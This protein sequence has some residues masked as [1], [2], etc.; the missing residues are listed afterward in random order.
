VITSWLHATSLDCQ[1]A[2]GGRTAEVA[3]TTAAF[4]P[5][6]YVA[7]YYATKAY[8]LSFMEA[9]NQEL[10]ARVS[11]ATTLCPDSVRTGFQDR[12]CE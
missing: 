6:S 10:K 9:L 3:S 12:A 11:I 1:N 4:Q 2:V 8:A 5:D 7:V